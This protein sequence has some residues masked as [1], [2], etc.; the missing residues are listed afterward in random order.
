MLSELSGG[1]KRSLISP[2]S[3]NLY[4]EHTHVVCVYHGHTRLSESI[5]LRSLLSVLRE[6]WPQGLVD[7]M[8]Q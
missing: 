8:T 6:R 7:H 1:F 2:E 3:S 4:L 5:C